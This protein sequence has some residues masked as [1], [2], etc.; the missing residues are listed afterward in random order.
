MFYMYCIKCGYKNRDG[1]KFCV[2]C[3]EPLTSKKVDNRDQHDQFLMGLAI[4]FGVLE[5]LAIINMLAYTGIL[6]AY[7]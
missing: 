5:I 7:F 3:G 6:K 4:V 1:S 2:N